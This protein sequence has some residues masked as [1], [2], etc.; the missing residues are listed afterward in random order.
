M[1]RS[2]S[3]ML[4]WRFTDQFLE[5]AKNVEGKIQSLW[6]GNST[7]CCTSVRDFECSIVSFQ[8]THPFYCFCGSLD[9]NSLYV[10]YEELAKDEDVL[11]D[12]DEEFNASSWLTTSSEQ[13]DAKKTKSNLKNKRPASVGSWNYDK[14]EVQAI[15]MVMDLTCIFICRKLVKR[16]NWFLP[17]RTEL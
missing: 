6:N 10:L 7:E 14:S 11:N 13:T 15:L 8:S 17:T 4:L 1:A 3:A 5:T 16:S 12:V 9:M 2:G